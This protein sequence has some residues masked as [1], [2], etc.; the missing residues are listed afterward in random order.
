MA[1]VWVEKPIY[2]DSM[3]INENDTIASTPLI[4][5]GRVYIN[6]NNILDDV[7]E[8]AWNFYIGITNPL[9]NG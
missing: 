4:L 9:K 6:E 3:L 1:I 7:P 8:V 2:K 5:M